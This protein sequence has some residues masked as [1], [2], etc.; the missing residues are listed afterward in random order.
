LSM[1]LRNHVNSQLPIPNSQKILSSV[2]LWKLG[3]GSW[4]LTSGL[5]AETRDGHG[6]A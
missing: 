5:A 4:E 2:A 1:N 3:V 6:L